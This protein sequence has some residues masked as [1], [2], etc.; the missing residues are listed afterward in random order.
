MN[1]WFTKS[2]YTRHSK[3]VNYTL[4][5][6]RG[7]FAKSHL[8]L[9]LVTWPNFNKRNLQGF[10]FIYNTKPDRIKIYILQCPHLVET[11]KFS[12]FIKGKKER[13]TLLRVMLMTSSLSSISTLHLLEISQITALSF[14]FLLIFISLTRPSTLTHF[15][16]GF[17][18]TTYYQQFSM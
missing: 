16:T 14:C 7:N 18:I 5:P 2:T 3:S 11:Q 6:P 12:G 17:L 10:S 1:K 15:V 8:K 4:S 9:C 13:H